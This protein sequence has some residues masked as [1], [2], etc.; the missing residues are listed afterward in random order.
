MDQRWSTG[1]GISTRFLLSIQILF[2]ADFAD[3]A[4]ESLNFCW[5]FMLDDVWEKAFKLRHNTEL[6]ICMY[7]KK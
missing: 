2:P 3:F 7:I 1:K 5:R 6:Y 4:D